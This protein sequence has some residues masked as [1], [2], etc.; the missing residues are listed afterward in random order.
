MH[1]KKYFESLFSLSNLE[2]F[3]DSLFI[4]H[5]QGLGFLTGWILFQN[6]YLRTLNHETKI[7]QSI[8]QMKVT[9]SFQIYLVSKQLIM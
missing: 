1:P 4:F 3:G 6:N 5:Y 7:M 8:A 9:V 2:N